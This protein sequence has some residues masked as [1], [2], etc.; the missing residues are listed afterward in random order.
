MGGRPDWARAQVLLQSEP[1]PLSGGQVI[2]PGPIRCILSKRD[3]SPGRRP[4]G[5]PQRSDRAEGARLRLSS[6]RDLRGST[7]LLHP[8]ARAT[9]RSAAARSARE[10]A[11]TV[12]RNGRGARLPSDSVSRHLCGCDV[13]GGVD[14]RALPLDAFM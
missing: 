7:P 12:G 10:G 8:Q 11:V 13:D 9:S 3:P 14:G 6:S 5:H 2:Q 4:H 1:L